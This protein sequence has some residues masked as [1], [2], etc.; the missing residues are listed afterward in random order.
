MPGKRHSI[1]PTN[2]FEY[3][4]LKV[5]K[6]LQARGFAG[7][8]RIAALKLMDTI[9]K[10]TSLEGQLDRS[11]REFDRRHGVKTNYIVNLEDLNGAER[12]E[13]GE[14]HQPTPATVL[15][16]ILSSLAIKHEDF[17]FVDLGCGM[18]RAAFLASRLPFKRIIGVEFSAE[19]HRIAEQNR[20]SFHDETRRCMDIEF[21]CADASAYPLP[22]ENAVFYLFNPFGKPTMRKVVENIGR[23]IEKHPRE[24]LIVYYNPA[25]AE[26]LDTAPFLEKIHSARPRPGVHGYA[27]YRSRKTSKPLR[28]AQDTD[29]H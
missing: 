1:V 20:L 9:R 24:I 10:A 15:H 29:L 19:L 14:R 2:T 4:E 18:G 28:G 5:Q 22:N 13:F 7:T 27:I 23:S 26:V 16:P 11:D 25:E 3:L 8:L 21:T 17:I 6:N 12:A